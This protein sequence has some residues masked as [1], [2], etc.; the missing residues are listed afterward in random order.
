MVILEVNAADRLCAYLKQR[1]VYTDSRQQRYLRMAPFV[2]NTPEEIDRA[3]DIMA[4]ALR[5]GA[6]LDTLP[7]STTK[8]G[9]VT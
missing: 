8:A 3:F 9:P 1:D 7:E 4:D 2:W 6:Y 5:S